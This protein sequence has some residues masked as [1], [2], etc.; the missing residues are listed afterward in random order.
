VLYEAALA[1][2]TVL[3]E[4]NCLLNTIPA[5]TERILA[6]MVARQHNVEQTYFDRQKL[7]RFSHFKGSIVTALVK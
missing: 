5:P 3:A 1:K 4:G 6:A 2:K 7:H